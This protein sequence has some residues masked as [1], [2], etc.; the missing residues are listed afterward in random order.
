MSREMMSSA[1]FVFRGFRRES[2]LDTGTSPS[3]VSPKELAGWRI[4]IDTKFMDF[5][6]LGRK[7]WSEKKTHREEEEGEGQGGYYHIKT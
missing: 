4:E 1:S 3:H 5:L 6:H 7:Q 2:L